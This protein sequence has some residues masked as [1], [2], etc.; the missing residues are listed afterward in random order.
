M[1]LEIRQHCTNWLES[2]KEDILIF[3]VNSL[4]NTRLTTENTTEIKKIARENF[5]HLRDFFRLNTPN[6]DIFIQIKS[7]SNLMKSSHNIANFLGIKALI[8][9]LNQKRAEIENI[10]DYKMMIYFNIIKQK[11]K[12]NS[13]VSNEDIDSFKKLDIEKAMDENKTRVTTLLEVN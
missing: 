11:I 10:W 3:Y 12:D 13:P 2:D 9:L 1:T 7:N 6:S 8:W 4:F 5:T